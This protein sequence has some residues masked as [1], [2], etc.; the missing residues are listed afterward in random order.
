MVAHAINPCTQNYAISFMVVNV[1]V[2]QIFTMSLIVRRVPIIL[3]PL[4]P[5]VFLK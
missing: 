5:F 4:L 2:T 1:V 3:P